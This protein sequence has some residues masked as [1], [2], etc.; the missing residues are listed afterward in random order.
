M[1]KLTK[2]LLIL[3]ILLSTTGASAKNR[4]Q[5]LKSDT[6]GAVYINA[7][8]IFNLYL[9]QAR[10]LLKPENAEELE[11]IE[12][13]MRQHFPGKFSFASF[14]KKL[15]DFADTAVFLPDGAL[16]LSIDEELL[17]AMSISARIKPGELLAK[18]RDRLAKAGL[19]PLSE[20]AELVEYRVPTPAFNLSLKMTQD[21]ITLLAVASGSAGISERWR[22]LADDADSK[23]TLIAAEVDI[24]RIKN[25]LDEK[26]Q[27][28]KRAES[29]A[30]L[31]NFKVL[32]SA[33]QLY[34]V[35]KGVEMKEFD[36]AALRAG[37]YLA[38]DLRC[39]QSGIYS[40]NAD[41][42]L[43][44]SIHGSLSQPV[45]SK[46]IPRVDAANYLKPFD[47]LRI[48]VDSDSAEFKTRINDKN[49]LEQWVAIGKQQMQAVRHMAANQMGQMPEEAKQQGLKLLDSIKVSADGDW[50][51]INIEGLEEKTVISGITGVTGAAAAIAAP[52][53]EKLRDMI[54]R[55]V[56]G[57]P[58]NAAAAEVKRTATECEAVRKSLYRVLESLL[59]EEDKLPES[60]GLD[61]L[62]EK[63]LI[64]EIPDCPAGGRYEL[65]RNGIDYEIRCTVHDR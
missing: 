3:V 52:H 24:E 48:L 4:A 18:V 51:K 36:H 35:D 38:E 56:R 65:R 1:H 14:F 61:Y 6:L 5:V 60:F 17:P 19:N 62:K 13:Q 40:L 39:P 30:C 25:W 31:A 12:A 16:W 64:K 33:M 49:L 42:E 9:G 55:N 20:T 34:K 37:G 47:S 46:N 8:R 22:S 10:E 27:S 58:G 59:V 21:S 53:V 32:S 50:L 57:Q 63:G 11:K 45:W 15:V 2:L 41:K 28:G 29:N 7:G 23:N 54:R 26:A 44:C 43:S